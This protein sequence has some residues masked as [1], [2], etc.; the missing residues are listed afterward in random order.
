MI[1]IYKITNKI[2]GKSYI[3]QSIDINKRW[4]EHKNTSSSSNNNDLYKDFEKYGINNFT[5]EVLEECTR[6]NLD[7]KEIYWI[8]QFNT[9]YNGYNKTLGGQN[10]QLQSCLY[11]IPQEIINIIVNNSMKLYLYFLSISYFNEEDNIY[12][13]LNKSLCVNKIKEM[14]HMHANTIKTYWSLLEKRGLIKYNGSKQSN[15]NWDEA[16]KIRKKEKLTFYTILENK[17]CFLMSQSEIKELL[18]ED[19][20][21]EQELKIYLILKVLM[22]YCN[23]NDQNNIFTIADLRILLNLTSDIDNNKK[24]YNS[25]IKLKH[26]NL[27]NY[28]ENIEIT[29]LNTERSIFKIKELR[30]V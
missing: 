13:F 18:Y 4:K 21:S 17:I 28:L 12:F 11:N 27:I 3:G 19:N 24:I 1:G 26:L 16:Y 9:Y 15:L 14:L 10:K 20:L 23:Y 2:N 29:N 8:S 30:L 5:F 6:Q 7:I 25:L 22:N